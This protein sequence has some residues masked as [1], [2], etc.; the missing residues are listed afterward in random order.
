MKSDDE[1]FARRLIERLDQRPL[2]P[3]VESRLR[4]ARQ[5]ALAGIRPHTGTAHGSVLTLTWLRHHPLWALASL[6]G[7]ATLVWFLNKPVPMDQ[8]EMDLLML[9]DEL[10]P[11]AYVNKDFTQWLRSVSH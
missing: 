3:Q 9:S 10:P 5:R 8:G 11:Q 7:L 2:E 6:V 4:Q 1:L